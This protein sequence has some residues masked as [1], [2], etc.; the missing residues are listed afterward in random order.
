M[1]HA[2]LVSFLGSCVWESDLNIYNYCDNYMGKEYTMHTF[3]S[4]RTTGF[5]YSYG[6]VSC[7]AK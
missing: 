3:A 5:N 1:Q 4:S 7:I 6:A 2:K